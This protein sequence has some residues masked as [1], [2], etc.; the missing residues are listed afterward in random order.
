MSDELKDE[1]RSIFVDEA[2][3][4]TGARSE[5]I[6]LRVGSHERDVEVQTLSI[7]E[8]EG[9]GVP[10]S[11]FDEDGTL[12]DAFEGAQEATLINAH[13]IA[14]CAYVPGTNTRI[15]TEPS[16]IKAI[17]EAPY[18]ASGWVSRLINTIQYLH[19]FRKVAPDG[20]Q[21]PRLQQIETAGTELNAIAE[22]SDEELDRDHVADIADRIQTL[23]QAM[24]QGVVKNALTR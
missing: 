4:D 6:S 2:T 15:F 20:I 14:K 1:Y 10:Q 3:G 23:A 13:R 11:C 16:D 19:G 8:Y 21:D 7:A 24:D 9:T 12:K 5:T 22:Q 17:F 18:N